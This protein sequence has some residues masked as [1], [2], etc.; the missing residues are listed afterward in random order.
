MHVP[1]RH[2]KNNYSVV[3]LSEGDHHDLNYDFDHM[4]VVAAERRFRSQVDVDFDTTDATQSQRVPFFDRSG[5]RTFY[6]V[7]EGACVKRPVNWRVTAVEGPW[8]LIVMKNG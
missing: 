6:V 3:A 4:T 1:N 5:L 2:K 8:K 7:K